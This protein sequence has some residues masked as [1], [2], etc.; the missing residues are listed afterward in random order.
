MCSPC[1]ACGKGVDWRPSGRSFA[2]HQKRVYTAAM[3]PEPSKRP[4]LEEEDDDTIS[5]EE[6]LELIEF[7]PKVKPAGLW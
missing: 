1:L 3:E 6:A 5:Y 4:R 7:D 2:S